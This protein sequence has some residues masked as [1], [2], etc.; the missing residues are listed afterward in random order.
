MKNT[1]EYITILKLSNNLI[2]A[3]KTESGFSDTVEQ[4]KETFT[5]ITFVSS[6]QV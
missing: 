2:Y 6:C 5:N 4:N 3:N 1:F